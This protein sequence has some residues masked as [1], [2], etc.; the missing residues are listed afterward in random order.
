[1]RQVQLREETLRQEHETRM[2]TLNDRITSLSKRLKERDK[3][4]ETMKT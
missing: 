4:I 3:E 1:M 2:A